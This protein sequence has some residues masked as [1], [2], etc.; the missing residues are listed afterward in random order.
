MRSRLHYQISEQKRIKYNGCQIPQGES[1]Y[2]KS[3]SHT[4]R[5]FLS[6][7][8][9]AVIHTQY[10]ATEPFSYYTQLHVEHHYEYSTTVSADQ[11]KAF[12][13]EPYTTGEAV[14]DIHAIEGRKEMFYLTTHSTHFIYG[15]MASDIW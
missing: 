15:Y 10:R 1:L 9:R 2:T 12:E 4:A 11:F 3:R 5:S 7:K 6:S 14:I 13:Q 8:Q